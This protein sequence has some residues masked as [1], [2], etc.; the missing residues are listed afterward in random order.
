MRDALLIAFH[1][2]PFHGSSGLQRTLSFCRNL[3]AHGWRPSVLTAHSRAYPRIDDGQV[4]DIP[5]DV[6]VKRAFALDSTRQ[7]AIGG[8]YLRSTALPDR[9]IS[10]LPAAVVTGLRLIRER[11]P[12]LLWSTYP[13]ATAHVIGWTL[14]RLTGLPWVADFR[15][16][17]V[18]RIS[19]T[20]ELFPRDPAERR[21]RLWVESLVARRAAVAVFCTD[22]ARAI[23]AERHPQVSPQRLRVIE[24]GFD[25]R[26]FAEIEEGHSPTSR[27]P[28]RPIKLLHSGVLYRSADRSPEGLFDALR[29]LLAEAKLVPD[30][31]QVVLRASGNDDAYGPMISERGLQKVVLLRPPVSYRQ[32]LA[33][34]L[35]ADGLLLFQ[36]YTSNPAI[37]AKAY[38]YLRAKRPVFALVD[39]E[40]ETAR[41]VA[42]LGIGLIA[43]LDDP[44]R[45][46]E[47]LL[48]FLDDLRTDALRPLQDS[49]LHDYSREARTAELAALFDEVAG[50]VPPASVGVRPGDS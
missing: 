27:A 8:R 43:P 15:D 49:S 32:A 33:E 36:G 13:I 14:H 7:L 45:I 5:P 12:A 46:A 1:F 28:A 10:W 34:M 24:N 48:L 17:M 11:Q 37:P 2:P 29:L 9:W 19:R 20:G 44:P 26:I 35:D 23:F 40:G 6:L 3:D 47:Q 25:E 41:L 16:P 38:E 50:K 21:A 42:R 22:S 4:D 18:E 30:S 31:L 39:A